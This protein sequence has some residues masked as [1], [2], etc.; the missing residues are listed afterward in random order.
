MKFR[1]IYL[2]LL[3]QDSFAKMSNSLGSVW[4]RHN[5]LRHFPHLIR[6]W[7]V[8]RWNVCKEIG[9]LG[10][11]LRIYFHW[12]NLHVENLTFFFVT[13]INYIVGKKDF[14]GFC[15]VTIQSFG[16][17]WMRIVSSIE[18]LFF[19][20]PFVFYNLFALFP[21]FSFFHF[22]CV[23]FFHLQAFFL[24]FLRSFLLFF[25]FLLYFCI[26]FVF[27]YFLFRLSIFRFF[28]LFFT[29]FFFLSF[30]CI[31]TFSIFSSLQHFFPFIS[32]FFLFQ[33]F[34]F[35]CF[36]PLF[37]AFFLHFSYFYLSF[38]YLSIFSR[39]SFVYLSFSLS[40]QRNLSQRVTAN[41]NSHVHE[42][43]LQVACRGVVWSNQ[44]LPVILSDIVPFC[45]FS[46]LSRPDKI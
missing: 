34:F 35:L 27:Y 32:F 44:V 15:Q 24:P 28:F 25:F 7:R 18:L 22:L 39:F 46:M 42:C 4:L 29:L 6:I 20:F 5:S 23:I 2:L 41:L 30:Y 16:P 40:F 21:S 45:I 8:W 17:S 11:I 1:V 36:F 31:W 37:I 13:G 3:V 10:F 19:L 9:L 38:V 12:W 33:H 43:L 14:F 26:F